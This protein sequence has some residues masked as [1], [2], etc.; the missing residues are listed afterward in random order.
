M[1]VFIATPAFDGKVNV[2]YVSS[3]LQ[4]VNLLKENCIPVYVFIPHG[5]SLLVLERNKINK[6]FLSS[7][8][9]HLLCIDADVGWPA[10][11]VLRLLKYD[12]DMV[13]G[14]CRQRSIEK[15]FMCRPCSDSHGNVVQNDY[16]LMQMDY[17][18]ASF[19]LMKRIVLER[20]INHFPQ[21]YYEPKDPLDK[22]KNGHC[23]FNTEVW[24]GEFWG[25]DY[26]FSRR[27]RESGTEIWI[28]PR[29]DFDHGGYKGN[30]YDFAIDAQKKAEALKNKGY[31]QV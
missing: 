7:R 15:K 31:S 25:E 29:I 26:V 21:L 24:N 9:T 4:T 13:G 6:Q 18:G 12:L 23:L 27:A 10:E 11:A 8:Y 14:I 22:D 28:D 1:S 16:G 19:M 30:F 17:I 5:S 2:Q 20:M 3:L